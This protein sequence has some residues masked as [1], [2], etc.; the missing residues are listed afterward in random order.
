MAHVLSR[1][2][3][4]GGGSATLVLPVCNRK[5]MPEGCGNGLSTAASSSV[6]VIDGSHRACLG[7]RA[8]RA[9]HTHNNEKINA[10]IW[11]RIRRWRSLLSFHE[12]SDTHAARTTQ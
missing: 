8:A 2:A 9:A 4:V 3:V 1:A 12:Q 7:A 5:L 11:S 10:E 6:A